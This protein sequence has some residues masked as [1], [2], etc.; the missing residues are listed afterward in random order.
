[1]IVF[2]IL[3]LLLAV[4]QFLGL[5]KSIYRAVNLGAGVL[6]TTLAFY[7]EEN[8]ILVG[9]WP[10]TAGIEWSLD[11]F[12]RVFC[13]AAG[14]V[15]LPSAWLI[16]EQAPV[17]RA[18]FHFMMASV[19]GSFLTF[20]LFNLFVM[21]E[22]LLLSMYSLFAKAS[23]LRWANSFLW[24]NLLSSVLYLLATA[25]L[26]KHVGAVNMLN[27]GERSILLASEQQNW[28][29][30]LFSIVF[31]TKAGIGPFCIWLSRAYESLPS[32]FLV[33]VA[34]LSTKVGLYAM[35]RLGLYVF[36]NAFA[37]NFTSLYLLG[38]LSFAI[39]FILSISQRSLKKS[40]VYF[41]LSHMGVLWMAMLAN[42]TPAWAAFSF[43]LL[44]DVVLI[45]ALFYFAQVVRSQ[46]DW[47]SNRWNLA[48]LC[49]LLFAFSGLPPFPGFFAKFDLLVALADQPL[50]FLS[51]LVMAMANL[52][53]LLLTWKNFATPY[54]YQKL[55]RKLPKL[56]FSVGY[57]G[58]VLVALVL[59][60]FSDRD[61]FNQWAKNFPPHPELREKF[62]SEQRRV[63][64]K[65]GKQLK[66]QD[67]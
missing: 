1:M 48:C 15:Y 41:A 51:V 8:T 13:L 33:A 22:I 24:V 64:D 2:L 31:L 3:P 7:L 10:Y 59:W 45:A 30:W 26:Y 17:K 6:L 27:V 4:F 20:D 37:T 38:L 39:P 5:S 49:L 23:K 25:S 62:E 19:F 11:S 9:A 16:A 60:R 29:F 63:I 50:L 53:F 12:S 67:L 61:D 46:I 35:G 44:Q 52:Y 43:Y 18:L 55:F 34:A 28:L 32:A 36:P 54:P 47:R 65:R 40:L 42:S 14:L 58:L 57:F 56:S 21:F 66:E